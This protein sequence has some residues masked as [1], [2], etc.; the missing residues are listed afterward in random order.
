MLRKIA[1]RRI[2]K[3]A[4]EVNRVAQHDALLTLWMYLYEYLLVIDLKRRK[5]HGKCRWTGAK[6]FR[7]R[8]GIARSFTAKSFKLR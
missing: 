7:R 6:S 5:V 2:T 8:A 1:S 3:N 4:F